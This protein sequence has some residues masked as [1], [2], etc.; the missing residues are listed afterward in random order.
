MNSSPNTNPDYRT[1]VERIIVEIADNLARL[2]LL[3]T[4]YRAR[5]GRNDLPIVAHI[6]QYIDSQMR[7]Q[8]ALHILSYAA[9]RDGS[10]DST[11]LARTA[12][13]ACR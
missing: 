4:A 3:L 1:L 13:R 12:Y 8:L 7:E 9:K 5:F 10:R 2:E 6:K 11:S